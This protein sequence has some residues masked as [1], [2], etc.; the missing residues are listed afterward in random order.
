MQDKLKMLNII[1]FTEM[2]KLKKRAILI[3]AIIFA[4]V[5]MQAC[6][7]VSQLMQDPDFQEG[8]RQGWNLTAPEQY[9]Y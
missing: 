7:S 1:I 8:F 6:G 4:A 2:K 5:T 9:R 3:A